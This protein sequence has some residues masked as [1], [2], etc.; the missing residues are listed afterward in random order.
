MYETM[1]SPSCLLN[2]QVARQVF[3]T[4][5]ENSPVM[6]IVNREGHHWPSDSEAFSKLGICDSLLAELW[7]KIDDGAEPVTARTNGYLVTATELATERTKCGYIAVIVKDEN[8]QDSQ[9]SFEL[10]EI[11]INQVNLIAKLI[12]KNSLLYELQMRQQSGTSMYAQ[13]EPALN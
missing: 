2:E 8:D 11:V 4:L 9:I 13:S 5:G 3:E 12:E 6:L 1:F 10:L 7:G